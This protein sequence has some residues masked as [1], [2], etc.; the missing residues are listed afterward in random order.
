VVELLLH[1]LQL[2]GICNIIN[3]APLLD[4]LLLQLA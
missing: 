3:L 4:A 1:I 2:P